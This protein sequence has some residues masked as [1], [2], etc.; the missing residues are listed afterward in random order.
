MGLRGPRPMPTK[1]LELRGSPRAKRRKNEP[2]PCGNLPD[3]PKWLDDEAKEVY[4]QIVKDLGTMGVGKR[5]DHRPLLRYSRLWVRWKRADLHL[6]KYGES[7]PI[8][9]ADG[10]VKC[11]VQFPEVS[12]V[13]KLSVLLLRIEQEFGLTPSARARI[14]VDIAAPDDPL[15]KYGVVA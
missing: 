12:I 5:P 8:K 3:A 10:S 6:Q 4:R 15:A 11:F 7:Y 9:N 13:A 14:T 2:K 1:Q